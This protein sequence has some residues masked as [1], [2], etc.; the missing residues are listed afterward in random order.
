MWLLYM[1][2]NA[3]PITH[4]KAACRLDMTNVKYSPAPEW[5]IGELLSMPNPK[6]V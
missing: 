2:Y 6:A 1:K 3:L 5:N 4:D